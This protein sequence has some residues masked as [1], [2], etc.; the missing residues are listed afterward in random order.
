MSNAQA[1]SKIRKLFKVFSVRDHRYRMPL[2]SWEDFK[3]IPISAREDLKAFAE[4]GLVKNAFNITATSG[5]TSSRMI[6]AHS[7][8]AYET[9]LRRLVK[10]YR[11]IG[12]KE[13][14]LCLNLCA[15]ELNSGGRM[16]EAAFK[17]AGSGVIPFGPISTPD[18]VHEAVRLIEM[19]K[20]AMVNAYTNQLFDLFAVLGRK[21]SIRRCLVN[22]EPLWP[23][24][25]K[26]IEKMGGVAVYDHYGA[27][28][29]SGLAVALKP[30]DEYMK[31]VADGLLLEVLEDSGKASAIGIGTLLVTD[32]D[33]IS[34]PLIRYRIG[35]RV[36][37]VR[38]S[39]SL[40]IKVLGRTEDSLLINGV[41]VLKQELIRAVNNFLGHPR[42]FFVLDKHPEKY[43]DKLL[44][45]V[46]DG[47][48]TQFQAL[49]KSV[50]KAV[51]ADN[52]IDV[53]I[54]QGA[55]PRT[56]NGKIKYFIDARKEV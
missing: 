16:M 8:K 12:V 27:M 25:R 45:N 20:P 7:R 2:G 11:H 38:R 34:M 6:I 9:H 15:Y 18:Q 14:M 50:V 32:L 19:L 41:V 53:R 42:F 44:I 51:G 10:L 36:K 13:G 23:E 47:N 3:S 46:A 26:R 43:H 39:G 55:I 56:L 4:S 31:V 17:S 21:H 22:G 29:I 40:W 52:C 5:S 30:D 48:P 1:I 37:L 49:T 28:E 24:Y 35:D 54:H 33:N